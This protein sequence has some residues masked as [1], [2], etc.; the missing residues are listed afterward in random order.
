MGRF[1]L[2][3]AEQ[4]IRVWGF[5]FQGSGFRVLGFRKFRVSG[6]QGLGVQV[7]GFRVQS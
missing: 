4:S 5:W 6:V 3:V 7:P 2:S 1:R